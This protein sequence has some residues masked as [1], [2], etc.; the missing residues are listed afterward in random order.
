M[1]DLRRTPELHNLLH[2]VAE[3]G[4]VHH[5]GTCGAWPR[6]WSWATGGHMTDQSQRDVDE[7]WHARLVT[8]DSPPNPC[9]NTCKLTFTG[10]GRL[11]EWNV[12]WPVGGVA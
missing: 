3:G 2:A 5:S 9:G 8:F 11:S 6:G 4:I 12:R 7:L 10:S 1:T